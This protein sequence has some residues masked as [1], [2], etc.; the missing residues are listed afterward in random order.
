MRSHKL[1]LNGRV[2]SAREFFR[3]RC[4]GSGVAMVNNAYSRPLESLA[5]SCHR[6]LAAEY[7]AEARKQGLRGIKWD[8]NGDCEITCRRDRAAWLRSQKQYDADG[9]YSD[10]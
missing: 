10:G 9:G 6:E 7:N 3:K 8:H 2:V 1:V 5:L 4:G